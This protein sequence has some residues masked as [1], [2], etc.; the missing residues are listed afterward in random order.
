MLVAQWPKLDPGT[1]IMERE[2]IFPLV[3]ISIYALCY[4]FF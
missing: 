4:I 3:L 2:K 1:H